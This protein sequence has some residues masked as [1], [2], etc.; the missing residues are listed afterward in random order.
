MITAPILQSQLSYL[1]NSGIIEAFKA[2]SRLTGVDENLLLAIASRESNMGQSLDANYTGDVGGCGVLGC[3]IGIMQ[4]DRRYH[5]NYAA[6]KAPNDHFSNVLKAAQI[7]SQNLKDF[8]GKKRPAI[9]AY[10]AGT[11]SVRSAI[12]QNLNPDLF[13]TG[14]NYS[15]DVLRRYKLINELTGKGFN[16]PVLKVLM[17]VGAFTAIAGSTYFYLTTN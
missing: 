13:T 17:G 1:Q 9:A 10:N 5:K 12:L 16:D 7:L 2:A 4:I 15:R 14:Q 8:K 6:T 3:G 11:G